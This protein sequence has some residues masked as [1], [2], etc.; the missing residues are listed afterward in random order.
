VLAGPGKAVVTP[1]LPARPGA[2]PAGQGGGH[3]AAA[4]QARRSPGR[5]R[6]QVFDELARHRRILGMVDQPAS[7]GAL[8]V[9]VARACGHQVAFCPGLAMRRIADLHRVRR[10]PTPAMPL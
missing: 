7:I 4:G 1:L 5:A 10:R 3:A 6:R 9:A 2:R 8:P